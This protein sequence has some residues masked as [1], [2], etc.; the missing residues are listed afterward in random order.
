MFKKIN[1][2]IIIP[3]ISFIIV[4][5]FIFIFL[6][7]PKKS[8]NGKGMNVILITIDTIRADHVGV[9][10]KSE[11]SFTPNIDKLANEGVLFEHCIAHAPLTLPS[12]VSILSGTYPLY[13]Q[14][15]DNGSFIVPEE[16][17][18]ISEVF[19]ENDYSTS[20]F[21]AAFVL[22]S[23]WGIS[24]GF[25]KFSDDFDL[26]QF[27]NISLS[28]IEFRAEKVFENAEKWIK[29]NKKSKFFSWIHLYD[30]HFPYSPPPPFDSEFKDYPYKGEIA[31]TDYMLGKFIEFLKKE[32]IFDNTII[33][34]T[35]DHGEGLGDH[36]EELH[37]L[38]IYE[39]TIHVPTLIRA[40]FNFPVDTYK[41][42]ME[43]VDLMPTILDISGISI[44]VTCQ[45]R[46]LL[47]EMKG[48]EPEEGN[49]S[50]TESFYPR[51]HYG[52]SELKA[53]YLDNYKF[54]LAPKPELYD[55][56][57]DKNESD[58]IYF[59]KFKRSKELKEMLND[60]L[61]K[62]SE[63]YISP[64]KN[65]KMSSSDVKRFKSLGYLSGS[66]KIDDESK[67]ADPKEKNIV[68]KKIRKVLVNV[69]KKNFSP[70]EKM[71]NEVL[72]NDPQIIDAHVIRGNI[73][74]ETGK[75][76]E[77]LK[78]FDIALKLQPF[79]NIIMG[80]VLNSYIKLK[81][82]DEGI[83]RGKDFLNI[84]PDDATILKILGELYFRNNDLVNSEKF[85]ALSLEQNRF[86]SKVLSRLA[87]I[88]IEKK[89]PAKVKMYLD[90]IKKIK[91]DHKM[92]QYLLAKLS[93]MEG[94]AE[95]AVAILE[96]E[97]RKNPKNGENLYNLG[98][99]YQRN[100]EPEKA[101][102]MFF[103]ALQVDP[104][105]K[106]LNLRIA[107]IHSGRGNY[108][109]AIARL[110]KE[111]EFFPDSVP[112]YYNLGIVFFSLNKPADSVVYFKKALELKPDNEDALFN[113]GS[114]LSDLGKKKEAVHYFKKLI[115]LNPRDLNTQIKLGELL[116]RNNKKAAL[117][118]FRTALGLAV[119]KGETGL[120]QKIRTWINYLK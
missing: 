104:G 90:K 91:P 67:L 33:I 100:R 30:P 86:N 66:I 20:A 13:H 71:I 19:K 32:N 80:N 47:S 51:F 36:E 62:Y 114:V 74:V 11:K 92:V 78:S 82:Y 45:G 70:A 59:K 60:F 108:T 34:I 83:R 58:N 29:E 42:T 113:L 84:F 50:Y 54:I 22:H 88:S 41:R 73:C 102:K 46:S 17:K 9:Y 44:P 10:K 115:A 26:S 94:N 77:A 89:E 48:K 8:D 5:A 23:K 55:I 64:L 65:S 57:K 101:L 106:G 87:E 110:K 116:S 107:Q 28:D 52:W 69:H 4:S 75:Y 72:E 24:Q 120:A 3:L 6:F 21:I 31:Y 2:K 81:K 1:F 27:K 95:D 40:P 118:H 35:G 68:V 103:R 53:V 56:S 117:S 7:I 98:T 119:E 61:T 96:E 43:H 12:H 16:L 111:I 105:L 93:L 99:L 37:G 49:I 85:F 15:R 63:N 38:F 18:L 97:T 79:Y 25:D 39:S 109:E 76:E 112:A 14:V